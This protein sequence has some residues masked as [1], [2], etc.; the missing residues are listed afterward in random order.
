MEDWNDGIVE[1]R[2]TSF[3]RPIIP[4]FHYSIIPPIKIARLTICEE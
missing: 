2:D 4:I 1:R 3:Y